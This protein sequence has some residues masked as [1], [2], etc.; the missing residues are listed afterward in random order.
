MDSPALY[1]ILDSTF[2]IALIASC[3]FA[4]LAPGSRSISHRLRLP[5]IRRSRLATISL[6]LVTI[7]ILGLTGSYLQNTGSGGVP[8]SNQQP[9]VPPGSLRPNSFAQYSGTLAQGGSASYVLF[10]SQAHVY[11]F[12]LDVLTTNSS[13]DFE[14]RLYNQFGSLVDSTSHNPA[15]Q[16]ISVGLDDY[17]QTSMNYNVTVVSIKGSANYTLW[18]FDDTVQTPLYS[19]TFSDPSAHIENYEKTG[20]NSYLVYL[21][22]F[23][24]YDIQLT[25]KPAFTDFQ[26]QI[27]DLFGVVINSTAAPAGIDNALDFSW[28]G[29]TGYY[30]VRVVK[31]TQSPVTAAG[32][33]ILGIY[34]LYVGDIGGNPNTPYYSPQYKKLVSNQTGDV[35]DLYLRQNFAYS[36]EL[37]GF[38]SSS[39][40]QIFIIDSSGHV[41]ANSSWAPPGQEVSVGLPWIKNTGTYYLQVFK[42][43]GTGNYALTMWSLN[44]GSPNTQPSP[45]YNGNTSPSGKKVLINSNGDY[46]LV[47]L[48]Q[49]VSYDIE[50]TGKGSTANLQFQVLDITGKSF[51]NSSIPVGSDGSGSLI[52]K[53][54]PGYYYIRVF[55]VASSGPYTLT[56][57]R[58]FVDPQEPTYSPSGVTILAS[59]IGDIY[60]V[61]FTQG[62]AYDINLFP[63]LGGNMTLRIT[64]QVN[65]IIYNNQTINGRD[66]SLDFIWTR[67]TGNYFVSFL[68][69]AGTGPYRAEF[70]KMYIP[71]IGTPTTFT[72]SFLSQ[73]SKD[74]LAVNLEQNIAYDFELLKPSGAALDLKLQDVFGTTLASTNSPPGVDVSLDYVNARPPGTYY[75]SINRSDLSTGQYTLRLWR[76][77]LGAPSNTGTSSFSGKQILSN[78]SGDVYDVFLQQGFSYDIDL[79]KASTNNFQIEL[80][81]AFNNLVAGPTN[82]PLGQDTSLDFI[83]LNNAG[84]AYIR[85]IRVNG[86]GSYSLTVWNLYMGSPGT[87]TTSPPNKQVLANDTGDT[88]ALSLTNAYSYS[89]DLFKPWG[90]SMELKL[91]DYLGATV[92]GPT[93]S[94]AGQS[95]SLDLVLNRPSGIYYLKVIRVTG[96]G[97]YTLKMWGLYLG[98]PGTPT[99]ASKDMASNDTGDIYTLSLTQSYS[100]D[101]NLYKPSGSQLE[102]SLTNSSGATIAGPTSSAGN[103]IVSLD[104]I[105]K[106]NSGFY[107]LH[108]LRSSGA[109]IYSLKLWTLSLGS[110]GQSPNGKDLAGVDALDIYSVNLNTGYSYTVDL[111]MPSGANFEI[112]LIAGNGTIYYTTSSPVGVPV[113]LDFI[114]MSQSGT[115]YIEVLRVMGYG[116]YSLSFTPLISIGSPGSSVQSFTG[117][118]ISSSDSM[119]IWSVSLTVGQPY[120]FNLINIP[121]NAHFELSLTNATGNVY[122]NSTTNTGLPASLSF[123]WRHS[124]STY[125]LRVLRISGSGGYTLLARSPTVGLPSLSGSTLIDTIFSND[126]IATISVQT[127]GVYDIEMRSLP[128]D[129]RFGI[130]LLAPNG[131]LVVQTQPP[132]GA[133]SG[134][135]FIWNSSSANAY[136]RITRISGSGTF[137]LFAYGNDMGHVTSTPSAA[138]NHY[139][140]D[141]NSAALFKAQL[142]ANYSYAFIF[143]SS[144]LTFSILNSTTGKLISGPFGSGTTIWRANITATYFFLVSKRSGQVS[145]DLYSLYMSQ[146]SQFTLKI[147][148]PP[149]NGYVGRSFTV[150]I[151]AQDP[152]WGVTQVVYQIDG[153]AWQPTYVLSQGYYS[154]QMN[155]TL[156]GEG[157]HTITARAT[158][159]AGVTASQMR[160]FLVDLTPPTV[161]LSISSPNANVTGLT[162]LSNATAVSLNAT[163]TLSGVQTV[164][165]RINGGTWLV[166]TS[167]FKV[168]GS[169]GTYTI[170]YYAIDKAGNASPTQ[171]KIVVLDNTPPTVS[172]LSPQSGTTLT[173]GSVTIT[174]SGSDTGSGVGYYEVKIDS[175]A[176]INLGTATSYTAQLASGNHAITLTATDNVGNTRSVNLNF[177]VAG[178]N[179][180]TSAGNLPLIAGLSLAGIVLLLFLFVRRR[181]KQRDMEIVEAGFPKTT[182]RST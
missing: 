158:N 155:A 38:P 87:P 81:D 94:P 88:Y 16:G 78:D 45:S 91:V 76:M 15:T 42:V 79:Q 103:D 156:L 147:V 114:W 58:L 138:I 149:A 157:L 125:Y 24:S 66:L 127:G 46:Y 85:V 124:S 165:Y 116:A 136:L 111:F 182:D 93:I 27:T 72:K 12:D 84:Y 129:A 161:R 23:V 143:Y 43:A 171:T 109:G 137:T 31:G 145:T 141:A 123:I 29:L 56:M 133:T 167:S 153:G 26:L 17:I 139:L 32:S 82:A 71:F 160:G 164:Y 51:Y 25:N 4:S 68:K 59:D 146:L 35:Y 115:Y 64:D 100:Y 61:S 33:Y 152:V 69:Q 173:S 10:L 90:A 57:W 174:W 8:L 3:R 159:G 18:V 122:F 150:I 70:W 97:P 105:L 162:Y 73:D 52:W 54:N 102:L 170:Q 30:F 101:F 13:V 47:W 110:Q 44:L 39:N 75:L 112:Q 53:D 163:D 175:G 121:S 132:I 128:S 166:Y 83:W 154:A 180:L 172:I 106:Q 7:S 95:V 6:V 9:M 92:A 14:L 63:T 134:F 80:R 21:E 55:G 11:A 67:S 119:D 2:L 151:Q 117:S 34:R 168:T 50:L 1:A 5:R 20:G 36:F 99:S 130:Q 98:V 60:T 148:D 86:T 49:F 89:L 181:R 131:G 107:Y 96:S 144:N 22:Q 120:E 135:S 41:I 118:I 19:G 178:T 179:P 113:S 142:D 28:R 177:A 126:T 62:M 140:S 65:T 40:F 104:L 108:V 37:Q 176:F 74:I 77:D 169:D 48:D